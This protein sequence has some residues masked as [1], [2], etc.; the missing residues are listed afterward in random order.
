MLCSSALLAQHGP[1]MVVEPGDGAP[2]GGGGGGS[3]SSDVTYHGGPV[4]AYAKVVYLFWGNTG[5]NAELQGYRDFYGGM[6][7]HMAMLGQYNAPQSSLTGSQADVVDPSEPPPTVSDADV[8][9]KIAQYFA[10][11][12]DANTIYVVILGQGHDATDP[13]GRSSCSSWCAYQY[14]TTMEGVTVK[15]VVVPYLTATSCSACAVTSGTTQGSPAQIAEVS[16]IHEVHEVM[17]DPTHQGWYDAAGWKISDKCSPA[18][19]ASNVF[20]YRIPAGPNDTPFYHPGYT[21]FFQKTWSNS[22]HG[23]VQ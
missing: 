13:L 18:V 16:V 9:A 21:F 19:S 4:M 20:S 14:R 10:G 8:R 22:A 15:Y 5:Y 3:T 7:E 2:V 11:R 6:A 1:V 12:Y 23:C 17:T